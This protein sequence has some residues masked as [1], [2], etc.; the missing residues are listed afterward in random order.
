MTVHLMPK[1][2]ALQEPLASNLSVEQLVSL[3]RLEKRVDS[4]VASRELPMSLP[5]TDT[6]DQEA[7]PR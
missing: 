4:H 3:I 7:T 6:E 5:T 1:E 2:L